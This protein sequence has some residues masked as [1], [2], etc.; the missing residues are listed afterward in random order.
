MF[1]D[2]L[3]YWQYLVRGSIFYLIFPKIMKNDTAQ[4]FRFLI[5]SFKKLLIYSW[6]LK[7][8]D[9][10]F[11]IVFFSVRTVRPRLDICLKSSKYSIFVALL[12]SSKKGLHQWY[13]YEMIEHI[14]LFFLN[15]KCPLRDI[16]LQRYLANNI[17]KF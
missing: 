14:L 4:Y 5:L 15:T 10:F 7:Y 1:Y 6:K 12:L 8:P 11:N 3:E 9:Y 2:I 16:W 17:M 13:L